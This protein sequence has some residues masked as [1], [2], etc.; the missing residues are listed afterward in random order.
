MPRYRFEEF[1]VDTTARH[2]LRNGAPLQLAPKLFDLLV[3]LLEHS[4]KVVP[5][6]LLLERLWPKVIVANETV[7]R[8]LSMLRTALGE[9]GHRLIQTVAKSGY[10]LDASVH[11]EAE[12]P[13][14][15]RVLIP[16]SEASN[17][18]VTA[19]TVHAAT[20]RHAAAVARRHIAVWAGAIALALLAAFVVGIMARRA[21]ESLMVLALTTRS[22]DSAAQH[23]QESAALS[24][25][26]DQLRDVPGLLVLRTRPSEDPI[27]LSD[28]SYVLEV[29]STSNGAEIVL[30]WTLR[31]ARSATSIGGWQ[32]TV[33]DLNETVRNS[34]VK[35]SALLHLRSAPDTTA[36]SLP[37]EALP[38]YAGA[39]EHWQNGRLA[40]ARAALE[41]ARDLAPNIAIFHVDL[42]DVLNEQGYGT[43]A[44]VHAKRALEI[45]THDPDTFAVRLARSRA[46]VLAG[47]PLA[48]LSIIGPLAQQ[49]PELASIQL[50][51]LATLRAASRFPELL[52]ACDQ[53]LR[54]SSTTAAL[55]ARTLRQ[56]SLA[57][58]M[59]QRDAL[60]L[61]TAQQALAAARELND[62]VLIGRAQLSYYD[63]LSRVGD[64]A[65]ASL[66]LSAALAAFEKAGDPSMILRVRAFIMLN[67]AGG[68]ETQQ[69]SE[70]EALLKTAQLSGNS[71]VEVLATGTLM[72]IA[73]NQG[74][75]PGLEFYARE[76][77]RLDSARANEPARQM[78]QVKLASM[79]L[80]TG[81]LAQAQQLLG[82]IHAASKIFADAAFLQRIEVPLSFEA[83]DMPARE[84]LLQALLADFSSGAG[85]SASPCRLLRTLVFFDTAPS[86]MIASVAAACAGDAKNRDVTDAFPLLEAATLLA[87]NSKKITPQS[88]LIS[89]LQHIYRIPSYEQDDAYSFARSAL[90]ISTLDGISNIEIKALIDFISLMQA[91]ALLPLVS[92]RLHLAKAALLKRLGQLDVAKTQ[93]KRALATVS[94][95]YAR[96]HLDAGALLK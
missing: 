12:V 58:L 11:C 80:Y 26:A 4:G 47:E 30:D 54:A 39:L 29:A 68:G 5:R 20:S 72:E 95:Q 76:R 3:L 62:D 90:Q 78:S 25:L 36:A 18:I 16:P 51:F 32:S 50:Q 84:H 63:T 56:K 93:A 40:A 91:K 71:A 52:D 89:Q 38:I 48:G 60:A 83:N 42:A 24:F 53:L 1:E 55:R 94:M 79:L 10:R 74:D 34:R 2:A 22:A 73:F 75:A 64:F 81:E 35:L 57:L 61:T 92:A 82:E 23:W 13:A 67:S 8:T 59:L 17:E 86:A 33:K 37:L 9:N 6:E 7:T 14:R 43:L 15:P 31:R 45:A 70:A 87:A 88:A 27:G 19:E 85:V 41:R 44:K 69:R 46:L 77:L 66:A 49:S 21:P 28:A 65:T 96:I